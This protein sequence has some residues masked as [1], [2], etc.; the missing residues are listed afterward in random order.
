MAAS[1]NSSSLQRQGLDASQVLTYVVRPTLNYLALPGGT[2]AERLVMGTAAHE[3]DGFRY[4]HQLGGGPALGLFQMEPVTFR[5]LWARF[6]AD[7]DKGQGTA[8]GWKL[9]KLSGGY[10]PSPAPPTDSHLQALTASL[11]YNLAFAAAMC[12]VHYYARPFTMPATATTEELAAIW[13]THYNTVL[14]KG[15]PAEFVSR[16]NAIIDPLYR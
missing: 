14:G 15:K 1:S 13:K 5:D 9:S 6:G 2:V 3:S 4:L 16:Y 12:R 7:P 10:I 8:L 11:T